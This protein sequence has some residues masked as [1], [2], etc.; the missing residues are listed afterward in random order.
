MDR[1]LQQ[2]IYTALAEVFETIFLISLEPLAGAAPPREMWERRRNY[3]EV[4]IDLCSG[5]NQPAFFFFPAGLVQEIA[6]GFLGLDVASLD[7][8]GLAQVGKM[9]AKMTIGGLLARV[10]PEALI[11]AGE[12]QARTIGSFTPG[13]LF[14]A[15][16]TWVYKTGQGYL[17]VDVG[18]SAGA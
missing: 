11:R 13:R 8:G 12:P 7:R 4:R 5:E 6:S 18:R 2:G 15:P 1:Y 9:A 3:L 16:W 17:W 14:E 10:D